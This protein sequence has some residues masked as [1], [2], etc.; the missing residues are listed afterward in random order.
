[1]KYI[2]SFVQ[3]NIFIFC[4]NVLV[5][6]PICLLFIL[7]FAKY[8]KLSSIYR[9]TAL[10]Y[11]DF[12]KFGKIIDA[13]KYS[14]RSVQTKY[15]V[16][17]IY[18]FLTQ[19]WTLFTIFIV[20]QQQINIFFFKKIIFEYVTLRHSDNSYQAMNH[21]NGWKA[22]THIRFVNRLQITFDQGVIMKWLSKAL[23]FTIKSC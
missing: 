19:Y 18:F 12:R 1:M 4:S 6:W 21:I 23:I 15:F 22:T 9:P 16:R 14:S 13:Y 5:F 3:Y 10:K 2:F 20:N 17:T 7:I 11:S 8:T